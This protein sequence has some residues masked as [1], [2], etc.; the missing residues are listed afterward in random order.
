[1]ETEWVILNSILEMRK[2]TKCT[3][4]VG[5]LTIELLRKEL[6]KLG[7]NVSNRDVFIKE[8]QMNLTYF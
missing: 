8:F 3:K 4:F 5:A 6:G 1:M 2:K 7:F